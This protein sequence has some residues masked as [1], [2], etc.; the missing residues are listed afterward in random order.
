ML[1]GSDFDKIEFSFLGLDLLE[2][3][4]FIGDTLI[5]ITAI[6]LGYK[7]KK[8]NKQLVEINITIDLPEVS[9]KYTTRYLVYGN[10]DIRVQN[11]YHPESNSIPMLPR[12]GIRFIYL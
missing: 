7:T 6:T 9:S 10:G 11:H 1:I 4:A 8:I 5:L 12:L 2:P 3:N